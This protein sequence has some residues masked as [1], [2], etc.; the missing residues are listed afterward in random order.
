MIMSRSSVCHLIDDK[1]WS[2]SGGEKVAEQAGAGRAGAFRVKL[3]AGEI[4]ALHDGGEVGAVVAAGDGELVHRS[5]ETVDE[6]EARAGVES[7]EQP[8][9]AAERDV[10]P[11]HVRHGD[12]G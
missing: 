9:V 6:I 12:A 8:G 3:H 2:V 1:F 10:V 11:A 4:T 7:G 5:G